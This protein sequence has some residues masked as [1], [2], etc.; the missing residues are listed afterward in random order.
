MTDAAGDPN[1]PPKD[2]LSLVDELA[3]APREPPPEGT[4]TLQMHAFLAVAMAK[5]REGR[6]AEAE[7]ECAALLP[8]LRRTAGPEHLETLMV[9]S[10]RAGVL[11]LLQRPAEACQL[12]EEC[13]PG[14]RRH[15]GEENL[16]ILQHL[17]GGLIPLCGINSQ[18]LHDDIA[19]DRGYR[20]IQLHRRD[21]W[22]LGAFQ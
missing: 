9:L 21:G 14:L 17:R 20:R 19:Q 8:L 3:N 1:N 15:W 12:Y 13:L 4:T 5:H 11:M 2:S 7:T 22:F 6:L 18:T 16:Q 10:N